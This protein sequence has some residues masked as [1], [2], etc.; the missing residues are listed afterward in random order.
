MLLEVE[1]RHVQQ[2]HRLIKARIYL[3]LL[4]ELSGL[5]ESGLH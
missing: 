5:I 1:Q 4:P 2:V 3:E